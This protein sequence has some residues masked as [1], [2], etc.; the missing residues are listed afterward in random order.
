MERAST[1]FVFLDLFDFDGRTPPAPMEL[2]WHPH[3]GVATVREPTHGAREEVIGAA[4]VGAARE[5]GVEHLI[6]STLSDVEKLTDGRLKVIHF[7]GKAHVDAVVRSAGFARHT[8][9]QAPFY[10]QNFLTVMAPQPL[11]GGGR[12]W[13]VPIDPRKRVIHAGDHRRR[14]GRR[15]SLH[16]AP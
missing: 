5:A 1:P 8:F 7:S 3:S 4:A 9:V 10:F 2:G 12:G 13:A 6:W 15:R 11:P 16:R 14:E